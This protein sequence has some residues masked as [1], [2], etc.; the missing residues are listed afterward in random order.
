MTPLGRIRVA[1]RECGVGNPSRLDR[2]SISV[3]N[4]LVQQT[5]SMPR[6]SEKRKRCVAANHHGDIIL[7]A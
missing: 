5:K 7:S 4:Y 3:N 1:A 2:N 6:F